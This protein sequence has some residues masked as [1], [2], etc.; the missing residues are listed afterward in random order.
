MAKRKKEVR[1]PEAATSQSA[2]G[3]S[4]GDILVEWISGGYEV[5]ELVAAMRSADEAKIAAAFEEYEGKLARLEALRKEVGQ[6]V[7]VD[8]RAELAPLLKDPSKIGELEKK[9]SQIAYE[10]R[11]AELKAE[12]ASLNT[13]G[14]EPEADT[15][16]KM[17]EE[18][19]RLDE[20]EEAIKALRKKIKERFFEREFAMHLEAKARGLHVEA[21]TVIILHMDGTLLAVKSKKPKEKLDKQFL[22]KI[23]LKTR[24]VLAE[25]GGPKHFEIEGKNLLV[26]PGTHICIALVFEGEAVEL[27][28]RM[29][30]KVIE[31]MERKHADVFKTWNGERSRIFDIDKYPTALFQALEKLE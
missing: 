19:Q 30:L 23:V 21:E 20:A 28:N 4:Y 3:Q 31:I 5:S 7:P 2:S 27:I 18:P 16:R 29:I 6:K 24:E 15:I 8:K 12:L 9:L 13:K 22:G 17:M 14:F 1:R 11:I 26:Q 10:P 25:R